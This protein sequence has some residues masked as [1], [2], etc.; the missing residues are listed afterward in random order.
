MAIK[1]ECSTSS[2]RGSHSTHRLKASAT[3]ASAALQ[4]TTAVAASKTVDRFG[5]ARPVDGPGDVSYAA[6]SAAASVG[7]STLLR[8]ANLALLEGDP[9]EVVGALDATALDGLFAG[10]AAAARR[11]Y[12]VVAFGAA[13]RAAPFV[14]RSELVRVCP[15]VTEDRMRPI[16]RFQLGNLVARQG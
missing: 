13:D 1:N 4:G 9:L 10:G 14:T 6:T 12:H 2:S 15:S 7:R 16:G 3:S 5:P 8:L 11:G